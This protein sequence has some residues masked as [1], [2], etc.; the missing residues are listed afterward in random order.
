V[1]EIVPL[2]E[3]QRTTINGV[4]EKVRIHIELLFN[5]LM[6]N[7]NDYLEI[8]PEIVAQLLSG[9]CAG[10]QR[11]MA[12]IA[13][14]RREVSKRPAIKPSL[15]IQ[16][17]RR[18]CW[19]CRYCGQQ[20]ILYPVMP[21][22][23]VIFPDHFPYHSNWKAGQTHPAVAVCTA[24]V[25]HVVPGSHGG[26]W[27]E[28]SNLVTACWPCNATK[29]DLALSELGWQ[30]RPVDESSWDGLSGSYRQLWEIAG[31]PTDE[32]H[33]HWLRALSCMPELRE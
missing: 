24:V 17:F 18:D 28:A 2:P 25:D 9:D 3:L 22:L 8:L 1:Q 23:G 26:A 29:G 7:R 31:K 21:L 33:P 10:A 14:T 30:L 5:R 19:T 32:A 6:P 13:Y 4:A 15:K 20:T 12:N 16:V 27:L 11:D